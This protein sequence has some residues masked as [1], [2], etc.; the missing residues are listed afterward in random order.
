MAAAAALL[1]AC[2]LSFAAYSMALSTLNEGLWKDAET[3][4]TQITDRAANLK[5]RAE[6]ATGEFNGYKKI[7]DNLVGNV[8]K[9]VQWLELLMA[10]NQ[11]L[12]QDDDVQATPRKTSRERKQ[13]HITSIDCQQ[14]D[15]LSQWFAAVKQWYKPLGEP[16]AGSPPPGPLPPGDAAGPPAGQPNASLPGGTPGGPDPGPSGKG[17]VIRI[18][19]RHYHNKEGCRAKR[20][21]RP[22]H[23]HAE[24]RRRRNQSPNRRRQNGNRLLERP[25]HQLPRAHQSGKNRNRSDRQSQPDRRRPGGDGRRGAGPA[26]NGAGRRRRGKRSSACPSSPSSCSSV[27]SQ[28]R[29]ASGTP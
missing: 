21:V 13:L 4:A 2:S 9:R 10:I 23:A 25:G 16:A 5:D 8:E 6:K 17:W 20:R 28:R 12:P 15:D 24:P 18:Q 19:G 22:Q 27:G 14:V 3:R 29:P 7:G 1:L 11:A 26:R